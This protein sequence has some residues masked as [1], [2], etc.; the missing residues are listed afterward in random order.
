LSFFVTRFGLFLFEV[1]SD[2]TFQIMRTI[3]EIGLMDA[4]AYGA[5]NRILRRGCRRMLCRCQRG[6]YDATNSSQRRQLGSSEKPY[7]KGRNNTNGS[8]HGYDP[9]LTSTDT[10]SLSTST[11]TSTSS[12]GQLMS[13]TSDLYHNNNNSAKL[14]TSE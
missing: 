14:Q 9:L 11:L 10:S 1:L 12:S 7:H 2:M 4:L 13:V 6:R 8:G 5:T 3:G